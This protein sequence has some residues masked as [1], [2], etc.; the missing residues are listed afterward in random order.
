[1]SRET[2]LSAHTLRYYERI[3]LLG[4]IDRGTSSGHRRYASADLAWIEFLE[5]LRATGIPIREKLAFAELR[6]GGEATAAARRAL[7]EGHLD[8]VEFMRA[9]PRL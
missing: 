6:R 9:S 8:V 7:L 4:P 3:G 2:D 5:R 1:M